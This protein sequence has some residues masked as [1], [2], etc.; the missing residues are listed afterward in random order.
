MLLAV[1]ADFYEELRAPS[2]GAPRQR[3]ATVRRRSKRL[4]WLAIAAGVLTL[5]VTAAIKTTITLYELERAEEALSD[6]RAG[7]FE[8]TAVIRVG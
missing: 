7:R 4:R 5:A 3:S 1:L 6:L 8:G 2:R